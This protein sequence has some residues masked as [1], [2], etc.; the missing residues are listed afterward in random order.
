M[1][2]SMLT[3]SLIRGSGCFKNVNSYPSSG[4]SKLSPR[5]PILA[6]LR[7]KKALILQKEEHFR[8]RVIFNE[9][10]E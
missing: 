5:T 6:E 3:L 8:Y 10:R 1:Q 7:P 2:I 4:V 9:L